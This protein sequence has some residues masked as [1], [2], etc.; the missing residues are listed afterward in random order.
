MYVP[1]MNYVFP[2]VNAFVVVADEY[3]RNKELIVTFT[4]YENVQG[5]TI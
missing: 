3:T 2:C 4:S 1:C 5:N